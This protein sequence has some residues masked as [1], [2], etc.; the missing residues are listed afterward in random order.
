MKFRPGIGLY[1][2]LSRHWEMGKEYERRQES[3]YEA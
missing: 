3:E 1:I 2:C